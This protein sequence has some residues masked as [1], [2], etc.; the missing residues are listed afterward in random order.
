MSGPLQGVRV[1]ETATMLAAPMC[2][3]MLADFGPDVIKVELPGSGDQMRTWGHRKNGIPRYWKVL[4]RNKRSI[5]LDL[6]KPKGRALFLRLIETA[7]VYIENFKPGT[8]ARWGIGAETLRETNPK[9]IVARVTGYGQ[10]GPNSHR[11]GF[12]TLAEAMSGF[13]YING[14]PGKPPTL[15]PFGL[16]DAIAGITTAFGVVAALQHR[17]RTSEGQDIDVALYEPILTVMGSILIDFQ[18]AGVIQERNG[19]TT[20]FTAPRNAYPTRDGQWIAVSCSTQATTVRFLTAI[21]R[22]ELIEDPLFLTNQLRVANAEALD[23]HIIDWTSAHDY[24]DAMKV[25]E[26]HGVTAG[27]IYNAPGILADEHVRARGSIVTV[28]DPDL[29]D[30]VMQAPTPQMSRTP[31]E[32]MFPA[33]TLPGADNDDIFK[34]FLGLSDAE[35]AS[36]SKEGVI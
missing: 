28:W 18:Q 15:P 30:V 29:G 16:A 32:I 19:N 2:G 13:A 9:L 1:I 24:A 11:A 6:R 25:F 36:L 31:G 26:A 3:M 17:N 7:D 10:T 33:R 35:L 21:G 27:P 4:G 20:P 22:P 34:G 23:K 8:P 5:S 14:W 12:G